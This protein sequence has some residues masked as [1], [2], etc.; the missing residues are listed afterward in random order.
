MP[1]SQAKEQSLARPAHLDM[2]IRAGLL[3]RQSSDNFSFA[4]PGL[5]PLIKDI[6][7]GRKVSPAA[8]AETPAGH[9]PLVAGHA[10]LLLRSAWCR[11]VHWQLCMRRHGP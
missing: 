3:T 11:W 1:R 7:E 2:L 4:I 10:R 8:D 9:Y 6:T 5:G